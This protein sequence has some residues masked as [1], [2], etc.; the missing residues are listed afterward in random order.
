MSEAIPCTC[1]DVHPR[2]VK[3]SFD[4]A[5]PYIQLG[6]FPNEEEMKKDFDEKHLS[7][8][9]YVPNSQ[10]EY[11]KFEFVRGLKKTYFADYCRPFANEYIPAENTQVKK[12]ISLQYSLNFVNKVPLY[13]QK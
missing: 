10:V 11:V 3:T 13:L 2:P 1:G 12:V 8:Q 7:F 4:E 6:A 9:Y 5:P